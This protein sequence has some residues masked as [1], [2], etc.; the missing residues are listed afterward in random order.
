MVTGTASPAEV[1][2]KSRTI[3]VVG[4]SR[5]PDKAAHSVPRYLKEQGYRIIP[6]NPVARE[7]L[8][9][10]AY[11]SLADIP[12]RVAKAVDVVEVFRP[13]D[14][15]AEVARQVAE[16]KRQCGRLLFF[17]AQEGLENDEAK[18]ILERSGIPYVMD[19]CMRTVHQLYV[20]KTA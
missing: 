4:A 1:L 7:I 10:A 20:R 5:N 15:L 11:R 3:A 8:G 2:V 13:S 18:S 9:E 12:Q 16:M 19:A 17:W 14:E 6:V